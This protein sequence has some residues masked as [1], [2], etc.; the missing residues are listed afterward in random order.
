[1][2]SRKTTAPA[3]KPQAVKA[4]EDSVQRKGKL[5]LE[6]DDLNQFNNRRAAHEKARREAVTAATTLNMIEESYR[7]WA[8]EIRASYGIGEGA[9]AVNPTTGEIELHPTDGE[10]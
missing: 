5:F 6:S 7:V 4:V 10:G 3:A 8:Q 1:M 9:F 2:A